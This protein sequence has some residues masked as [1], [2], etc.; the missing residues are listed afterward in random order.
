M[1]NQEL[2]K[3]DTQNGMKLVNVNVDQMRVFVIINNAGIVIY[4]DVNVK[5]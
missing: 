4:A 2:M 1:N 5:N 3:Q